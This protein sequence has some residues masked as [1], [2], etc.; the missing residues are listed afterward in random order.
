[1][2]RMFNATCPH[3][4]GKFQCHYEDLRHKKYDLL[5]P[6]CGNTFPQEESPLL[7]E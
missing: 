7:E 3:C 5:C 1:M 6:Y 2:V 4:G